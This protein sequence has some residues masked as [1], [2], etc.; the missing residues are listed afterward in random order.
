[1]ENILIKHEY[2]LNNGN[3]FAMIVGLFIIGK[4]ALD[5]YQLKL[6]HKNNIIKEENR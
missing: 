4:F 5:F 6:K 3:C 2:K 1:M